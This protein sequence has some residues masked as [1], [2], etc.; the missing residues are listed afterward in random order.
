MHESDTIIFP[1]TPIKQTKNPHNYMGFIIVLFILKTYLYSNYLF[2]L[3]FCN[4]WRGPHTNVTTHIINATL[5][6]T[7]A[8]SVQ[9]LCSDVSLYMSMQNT[10]IVWYMYMNLVK[11][12]FVVSMY[13]YFRHPCIRF[14]LNEKY[15]VMSF[16]NWFVQWCPFS[17]LFFLFR[18]TLIDHIV[19]F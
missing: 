16:M 8:S 19:S 5:I 15:I 9:Q 4:S 2:F 18:S 1:L 7:I 6:L 10:C 12:C 17:I 11:T 3:H 13:T 14:V